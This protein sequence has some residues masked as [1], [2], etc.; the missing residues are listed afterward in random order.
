MIAIN[1]TTKQRISLKKT[2]QLVEKFLRVY[3]KNDW[4]VSI[5]LVGDQKMKRLNKLY[6]QLDKTTDVLSFRGGEFMGRY[7]GEVIINVNYLKRFK[8]Y[9]LIF[10]R[11]PGQE[12]LFYFILIHGLLHLIGY[13]DDSE[14]N[15]QKMVALGQKF[16]KKYYQ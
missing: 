1:N 3:K 9:E 14:K 5:A 10:S 15:R 7:L 8:N 11:N 13:D 6:R 12:Y 2:Q 16:L 4:E